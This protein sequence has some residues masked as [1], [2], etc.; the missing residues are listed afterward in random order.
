MRACLGRA[1]TLA[2][3]AGAVCAALSAPEHDMLSSMLA[4]AKALSPAA[5]AKAKAGLA[6]VV[7]GLTPDDPQLAAQEAQAAAQSAQQSAADD[8]VNEQMS[9]QT[10]KSSIPLPDLDDVPD[11]GVVITSMLALALSDA[12][13]A[14][15]DS[16]LSKARTLSPEGA[17]RAKAMIDALPGGAAVSVADAKRALAYAQQRAA[18][19]AQQAAQSAHTGAVNAGQKADQKL[20]HK[21]EIKTETAPERLPEYGPDPQT[22]AQDAQAAMQAAQAAAQAAGQAASPGGSTAFVFGMPAGVTWPGAP[23]PPPLP[24]AEQAKVDALLADAA[25]LS[26]PE[27]DAAKAALGVVDPA[28]EQAKQAAKQAEVQKA[29]AAAQRATMKDMNGEVPSKQGAY[30]PDDPE[31]DALL[32]PPDAR[33]SAAAAAAALALALAAAPPLSAAQQARVDDMVAQAKALTPPGLAA[34]KD[35]LGKLVPPVDPAVAQARQAAVQAA[36]AAAQR[37]IQKLMPGEIPTAPPAA[38]D[39]GA[40]PLSRLAAVAGAGDAAPSLGV[41]RLALVALCVAGLGGVAA[42]RARASSLEAL[43]AAAG[44]PYEL[45]RA[46]ELRRKADGGETAPLTGALLRAEQRVA[47]G[48]DARV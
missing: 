8:R 16:L 45:H 32:K 17:E 46:S 42:L 21:L 13:Q 28:A 7:A 31:R 14:A 40:E 3:L 2:V 43:D 44:T 25:A 4:D 20:L 33:A 29:Q 15:L 5:M 23:T 12:E 10:V 30:P 11:D 39:G 22:A 35:A 19:A 37:H 41:P 38:T 18:Q 26:E 47:L 6:E 34:A 48:A 9:G 36:Q 1:V 24:D 27:L